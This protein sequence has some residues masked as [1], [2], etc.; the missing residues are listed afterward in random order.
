ME[1]LYSRS[2]MRGYPMLNRK[3]SK[4]PITFHIFQDQLE[5][6]QRMSEETGLSQAEIV[7]QF[8]DQGIDDYEID[9]LKKRKVRSARG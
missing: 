2:M 4:R 8:V 3:R 5:A 9:R 6:L 7:R 1:I